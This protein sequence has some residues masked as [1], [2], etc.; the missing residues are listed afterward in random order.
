MKRLVVLFSLLLFV[1]IILLAQGT[2]ETVNVDLSSYVKDFATYVISVLALSELVVGLFSKWD[3]IIVIGACNLLIGLAAFVLQLGI[4][5]VTWYMGLI[6]VIVGGA[7][8]IGYLNAEKGQ[9]IIDL[10]KGLFTKNKS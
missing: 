5:A 2:G 10:I 8:A 7:V 4:F 9:L 3:K 6:Y 1:P